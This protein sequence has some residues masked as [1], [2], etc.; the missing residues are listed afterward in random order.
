[1]LPTKKTEKLADFSRMVTFLYGEKKIGKTTFAAQIP[2]ALFLCT[3]EGVN[4]LEVFKVS[5]RTWEDLYTLGKELKAGKHEFTTLVFDTV[6]LA[7][8]LCE[9][10]TCKKLGI[11]HASDA[12]FGKGYSLIR[13]EFVRVVNGLA[14]L[15]LGIVFISHSKEKE[16]KKKADKWTVMTSTLGTAASEVVNGM[17]DLILYAYIHEDGR[18]VVRTKPTKY[19]NAGDRTGILPEIMPLDYSEIQ[20]CLQTIKGDKK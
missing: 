16:L 1:M 7:F 3:E 18:R 4:H 12:A 13:D 15:G 20:K 17:S 19:I 9:N 8:K 10:Y 6:D 5:I 2:G 14:Q 11:V